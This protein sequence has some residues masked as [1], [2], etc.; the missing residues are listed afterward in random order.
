MFSGAKHRAAGG[1]CLSAGPGPAG[2]RPRRRILAGRQEGGRRGGREAHPAMPHV[3]NITLLTTQSHSCSLRL[4]GAGK[5]AAQAEAGSIK[6]QGAG[7]GGRFD[8]RR[9]QAQRELAPVEAR[10]SG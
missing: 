7:G 9:R 5:G 2:H 10:R 3:V 1:P 8:R 4:C 6:R